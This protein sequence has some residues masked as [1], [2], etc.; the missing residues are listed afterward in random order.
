M[1]TMGNGQCI[2]GLELSMF[3]TLQRFVEGAN[4]TRTMKCHTQIKENNNLNKKEIGIHK[5]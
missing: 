5:A 3:S 4:Y 2:R 1:Q